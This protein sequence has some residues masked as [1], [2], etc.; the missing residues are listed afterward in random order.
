MAHPGFE[1]ITCSFCVFGRQNGQ[2]AQMLAAANSQPHEG[3]M[4]GGGKQ[5]LRIYCK[6]AISE[7]RKER[8]SDHPMVGGAVPCAPH[9]IISCVENV[10]NGEE[11]PRSNKGLR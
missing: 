7:Q 6:H 9:G 2:L 10:E 11:T 3:G 1:A 4:F 5:S 8:G